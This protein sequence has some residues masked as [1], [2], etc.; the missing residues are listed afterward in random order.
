M[1]ENPE[2]Q[3]NDTGWRPATA[4]VHKGTIRSQF[5]EMSEAMFLTSGYAYESAEQAEAR[6]KGD[7]EGFVYSRY[8][9]PTVAM[10]ETRMCAL[11]GAEAARGTASGMAA[12]TA[13]L[14]SHL[15]AGDHV[16]AG[17]VLFGSCLYVVETLL[18]KF[19]VESTLVDGTDLDAWA[20]AMRPNTRAILF[21]TPTN[22]TLEL[23]DIEGVC[24]L[25]REAGAL[26]VIDNVFATPILQ[27]PMQLGADVVVYSATKH[28]DGQGRCLG[29]IVLGNQDY[30]EN[31]LHDFYKHTGPSMSPFNAWVML[32]GLETLPLRIAHA[33]A[34]AARVADFLAARPEVARV[35]YPGRS[36]HP[37]HALARRQMASGGPL[38][39][40]DLKGG[41]AAAFRF[42]NAL[43]LFK[44]TNNLGDSKSLI[45]HPATTTHQRLGEEGRAAIGIGEGLLRLSLG[46]EDVED[47]L[48][49]LDRACEASRI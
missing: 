33:S 48:D 20:A 22:P 31:T 10:F 6:F 36:D 37:Q 30:I 47:L 25:A 28:I 49:D 34:S 12:V 13:A 4:L 18:P 42:M 32:K 44:I 19:G 43:K 15:K 46:L 35:L 24:A 26:S 1:A 38:V 8:S 3:E 14:L 21:E 40:F 23:V 9:N 17:R 2:L 16:V 45:T 41:K 27:R 39:S 5:G 29:G 11:E 7:L